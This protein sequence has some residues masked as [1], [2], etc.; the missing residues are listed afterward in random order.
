MTT[1]LKLKCPAKI[2]LF[3]KVTNKRDDGFHELES[4]LAFTD[5]EDELEVSQA[6][7]LQIDIS[8]EFGALIDVADNLFTKILDYFVAEFAIS[9]NLHIKVIKN[10]PVG[11]G[12]GGGSSNAASF[13]MAL[14]QI[15]ALGLSKSELQK[16]SLKFGSDIAFLFEDH[17]AIIQGRGDIITPFP[18][19]EPMA[20]LLVN[21]N[22]FIS[23]A[24]IFAKF[25]AAF[26]DKIAMSDLLQ[27]DILDLTKNLKNDL[28]FPATCVAP[29]I[30]TILDALSNAGA[31]ISKMS[32]S[33]ASCFGIF[34]NEEML[35]SARQLLSEKFPSFFIK[36]INI[37]S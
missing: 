10:I 35:E 31:S 16:I 9:P 18:K 17:A 11:G 27:R 20:A 24:D 14:N 2:N 29:E 22:I 25:K 26:S 5:L 7:Q 3:L 36:K 37:I 4:L 13:M 34:D 30:L 21:P 33:G 15:F 23:T 28:E 8:G 32:G 6:D 1:A 19:F 12:L